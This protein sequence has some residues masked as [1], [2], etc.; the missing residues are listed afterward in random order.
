MFEKFTLD[1]MISQIKSIFLTSV[2]ARL[3]KCADT[4]IFSRR[5]RSGN[6]VKDERQREKELAEAILEYLAEYP[7]ASDT[8]EGIAEWWIMR[9]QVRVEIETLVKVLRLLTKSGL[10]EKTGEGDKALYHLKAI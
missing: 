7:Q 2:Q 1:R 8:L 3:P 6:Q 5:E 4:R 9:Q 10:L